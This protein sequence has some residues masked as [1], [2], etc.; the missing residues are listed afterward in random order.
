M[1]NTL[2]WLLVTR[3]IEHAVEYRLTHIIKRNSV[4]KQLTLTNTSLWIVE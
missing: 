4:S 2:I 3:V 1:R